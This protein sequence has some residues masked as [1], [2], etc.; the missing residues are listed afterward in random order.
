MRGLSGSGIE[1][2]AAGA[3]P[4]GS[5]RP[6]TRRGL[7][8]P[9]NAADYFF[10]SALL[11]VGSLLVGGGLLVV[12]LLRRQPSSRRPS[13]RQPS[14]RLRPSCRRPSCRLRPSCRQP[15]CRLRPSCRRRPSSSA[16]SC[17]LPSSASAFLSAAFLSARPSCRLRPSSSAFL[18]APSFCGLPSSVGLL[19]LGLRRGRPSSALPSFASA[20]FGLPSA[21]A[22][23]LLRLGLLRVGLGRRVHLRGAG[24]RDVLA[25]L[26]ES[27]VADAVDLLHVLERLERTVLLAVV[28][29]GLRLHRADAVERLELF[30]GRG[31][32]VDGRERDA[33]VR[34]EG[35]K[36]PDD[37]L[38]CHPLCL[39]R[40]LSAA[41]ESGAPPQGAARFHFPGAVSNPGRQ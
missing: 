41:R 11:V 6:R 18:S 40:G 29:D 36:E 8:A 1:S 31:V 20:F 25:D 23:C 4:P 3:H 12:G 27:R 14:C 32:D 5:E 7:Q 16:P 2:I 39:L 22:S 26:V 33:R 15:S 35:Q 9:R 21:T 24:E 19:R 34:D 30:L 17:R 10:A 38:H 37:P 13:C 28:D